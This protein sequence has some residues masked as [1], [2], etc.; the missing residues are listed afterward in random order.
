MLTSIHAEIDQSSEKPTELSHSEMFPPEDGKLEPLQG[1]IING[2]YHAPKD[3]FSCLADDFG[4][5][6]HISQDGL[7]KEAA[8]VGFYNS[9]GDFKKAEVLFLPGFEKINLEHKALKDC[10][11]RFGIG[12]LKTVDQAQGIEILKEEMVD[13]MLFVAIS[14]EKMSV[15]RAQNGAYLSSTRGYL[16]FQEKDKLVVLS[17]QKVTLP[18]EQHAPKRH[19]E[20]LRKNALDFRKTFEF[21]LIPAFNEE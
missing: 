8:C 20:R 11:D 10:F 6:K 3:V 12:I 21:G 4:T 5:G 13:D 15:L 1:K 9:M 17:T 19:I 14:I 7:L 18:E 16:V 2:R